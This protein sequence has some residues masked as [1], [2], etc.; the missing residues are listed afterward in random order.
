MKG[1][2]DIAMNWYLISCLSWFMR[3]S[4]HR[5]LL[6]AWTSPAFVAFAMA[7]LSVEKK[8]LQN[9]NILR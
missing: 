6:N 2:S 5:R 3:A 7:R 8:L 1:T 4:Y 9:I